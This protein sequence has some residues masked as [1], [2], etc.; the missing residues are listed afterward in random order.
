MSGSISP[1][2]LLLPGYCGADLKALCTEAALYALRR[3]YPQIYA[4]KEKLQL[5]LTQIQMRARDFHQ[6]MKKMVPA[7]QRSV[8]SPGRALS[9]VIR[10]LLQNQLNTALEQLRR[11]MPTALSHS[12]LVTGQCRYCQRGQ[13]S[14][15]FI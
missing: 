6:A 2:P 7:A 8:V 13:F 5:D 3:Q 14:L 9:V 1:P 11:I 4:S 15:K 12:N 10:P